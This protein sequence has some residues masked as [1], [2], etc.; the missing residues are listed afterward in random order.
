M[1][2]PMPCRLAGEDYTQPKSRLRVEFQ[3]FA[4]FWKLRDA[5][6]GLQPGRSSSP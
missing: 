6:G 3:P 5:T 4:P 1:I 2:Q